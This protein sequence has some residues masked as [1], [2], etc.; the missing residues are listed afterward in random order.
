ML[1]MSADT[2]SKLAEA[3]AVIFL[4]GSYDGSGNYGDVTQLRATLRLLEELGE[5]VVALPVIDVRYVASHR[6]LG[7]RATRNFDP[8]RVLVFA[9]PGPHAD[10]PL[11]DLGLVPAALPG[12]IASATTY[13][14]GGGFL[15][16]RWAERMLK[17]LEGIDWMLDRSPRT[18]SDPISSG[19]QIEPAW[20]SSLGAAARMRL[21]RFACIGVRD[22]VSA[23]AAASI[24]PSD[25]SVGVVETGDDAV[26]LLGPAT[27]VTPVK[28]GRGTLRINL[29]ICDEPWVTE[30]PDRLR[31]FL[32]DVIASIA[33]L[34]RRRVT[35]Q[36]LIAYEDLRISERA[37]SGRAA[38]A[39][40]RT[41][42]VSDV[43]EPLVL[44]PATDEG[45]T[46][47]GEAELTVASSYH[48]TLTSLLLGVPAVLV[49]ENDYY[50][51]KA[52]GLRRD[53]GI[54]KRLTPHPA[55]DPW[56]VA[57]A[58]ST[59]L[60]QRQAGAPNPLGRGRER[61]LA[62]RQATEQR[63][64]ERLAAAVAAAESQPP[65]ASGLDD[66]LGALIHACETAYRGIEAYREESAYYRQES[67]YYR[68]LAENI[69]T[70]LSW[71]MTAPLRDARGW[72]RRRLEG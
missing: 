18:A 34:S 72:V 40:R 55:D 10:A 65:R 12:S 16:T 64:H 47:M 69:Q 26:G 60:E 9:Y 35:V 7:L 44:H 27:T 61:V 23:Q 67:A 41:A 53:F 48:V 54:S 36:P 13:M 5:Q 22:F 39:L 66:Q 32:I 62:R 30:E 45:A 51:Q 59:E 1:H 70:T 29:H 38:S 31:K 43:L 14:Y 6:V 42:G 52:A 24:A 63:I 46:R 25:G 4:V 37:T 49:A 17:M 15:N 58:V 19:L 50:A 68:Q 28:D 3:R 11:R 21:R 20:A 33:E 8:D 71:R 57:R 2:W 56:E